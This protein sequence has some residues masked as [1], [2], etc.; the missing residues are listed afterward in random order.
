MHAFRKLC[1]GFAVAGVALTLVL[2]GS[3]P[4]E[5][6]LEPLE[7][8]CATLMTKR[9]GKTARAIAKATGKCRDADIAGKVILGP[10]ES[11][12]NDAGIAKIAKARAGLEKI[13]S[14][15]CSHV[16]TFT[17]DVR[18]IDDI[19]CPPNGP[20]PE[21][22]SGNQ[23]TFSATAMGF[24]GPFCE[25]LLED[26][27]L[28]DGAEIGECMADVAQL[29]SDDL[30]ENVYGSVDNSAGYDGRTLEDRA[31]M[32][33][34]RS[35]AGAAPK[36][37]AAIA[38]AIGK[39][40]DTVN[41]QAVPSIEPAK[42]STQ[43]ELASAAIAKAL[44]KFSAKVASR[45]TDATIL[46]LDLCGNTIGGTATLD[47]AQ[48]CLADLVEEAAHS[49][50]FVENR[51]FVEMN[52][53]NAVYPKSAAAFCG[54]NLVNQAPNQFL[55]VGEECDG[56]SDD[57]CP[58]EC[59]PPGEVFECTCPTIARQRRFD[60][61]SGSDLDIG[62]NGNTFNAVNVEDSGFVST[63]TNCDCDEFDPLTGECIGTSVD[64]ICDVFSPTAPRCSNG[65]G[66]Q[67]CDQQ[68]NNNGVQQALDCNVCSDET[69]NPGDHCINE[70]DCQSQCYDTEGV[71]TGG[72]CNKQ[73][74]DDGSCEN[75]SVWDDDWRR[76][77]GGTNDG[78][79]CETDGDCPDGGICE[80]RGCLGGSND[81]GACTT[82]GDCFTAPEPLRKCQYGLCSSILS[83]KPSIQCVLDSDCATCG[84]G[85]NTGLACEDDGDCLGGACD[86]NAGP[87]MLGR[88][89]TVAGECCPDGEL[90]RGKCDGAS[91]C[92]RMAT[93]G[94][95]PLVS[96]GIP[97][98]AV[99]SFVTDV[100]GTHNIET[101]EHDLLYRVNPLTNTGGAASQLTPCPVCGGF[102]ADGPQAQQTCEGTCSDS[103]ACDGGDSDGVACLDDGDCPDGG[104]F[105]ECA[106]VCS[107][108]ETCDPCRFDTDCQTGEICTSASTGCPGSECRLDL[109]CNYGPAEGQPCRL[110]SATRFGI[111]SGDCPPD[112]AP[113]STLSDQNDSPARSEYGT[114]ESIYGPPSPCDSP[115]FELYD[116][117]CP[118]GVAQSKPN[119]CF[120]ACNA[121]AEYGVGCGTGKAAVGEYTV[122]VGGGNDGLNCDEDADCE[123]GGACTGNPNH[124]INDLNFLSVLCDSDADCGNGTCTDACPDGRCTPLCVVDGATCLGGDRAGGVCANNGD[125]DG[126]GECQGAPDMEEGACISGPGRYHCDGIEAFLPCAAGDVG[127]EKGCELG[128][129][130]FPDTVDDL[131]GT[132]F[133]VEDVHPCHV[134]DGATEGGDM[135][136][137]GIPDL[138][139]YFS[140]GHYCIPSSSS[141]SINAATGFP[142]P[143]RNRQRGR[144]VVNYDA[145]P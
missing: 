136:N 109:V 36:A 110:E 103:L 74:R 3:V 15:R 30:I 105:A 118:G 100:V 43:D 44:D 41:G 115:G 59:F 83:G 53:I 120:P 130:G 23:K 128:P 68:G 69:L 102:C 81:G 14:K 45:C 80:S 51:T 64:P 67:T 95:L 56:T 127:T 76:C 75:F 108:V 7:I 16:C 63:L 121:G 48:L 50:E 19:S 132:G 1:E 24:P 77:R 58:D 49:T 27:E 104:G 73:L 101:G 112:G 61:G 87:C 10:A 25:G 46:T 133:C 131:P 17:Q 145:I 32:K 72:T 92:V 89:V 28:T 138:L 97:S 144:F 34:L 52:L 107:D 119:K 60:S 129:D 113:V 135:L 54:D 39:C 98:C 134:N 12:P 114:F 90:C 143:G 47:E 142:G 86:G 117:P 66:I 22:C 91:F 70:L 6:E 78:N 139:H 93:S 116:C 140:V 13:A 88:S 38:A 71:S 94:P 18:C 9:I 85:I 55:R 42:C 65:D 37:A 11:C 137:G 79:D 141:P 106:Q 82:N 26:G 5:A 111:T 99:T 21:S 84:S 4:S 2:A 8:K 31:T 122:C 29:V 125:C 57:A 40:R 33:C 124:C 96:S 20:A 126:G 123:P 35:I 62:W